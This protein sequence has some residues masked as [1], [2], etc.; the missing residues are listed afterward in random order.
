MC[1]E[2]DRSLST[3]DAAVVVS[4]HGTTEPLALTDRDLE[5]LHRVVNAPKNRLTPEYTADER[6]RLSA[7]SSVG[8]VALPDGPTV[9]IRPK[10]GTSNL[11]YLL[12]YGTGVDATTYDAS[13]PVAAGSNFVEALGALYETELRA[14]LRQG[15][16]KEYR[17]VSRNR[18]HLRGRLEVH[19]Q[20]GETQGRPPTSFRCTYDELTYDTPLN[21][22][23]HQATR[24]LAATVSD[25]DLSD[26]LAAHARR[27]QHSVTP[28]PVPA[29]TVSDIE[30]SR[31]TA[32]YRDIVRLVE[33]VLGNSFLEDYTT[34][35]NVSVSL[36]VN[37]N[38]VFERVVERAFRA[39]VCPERGLEVLVRETT[40]QLLPD[41]RYEVGLEPDVAV[42]MTDGTVLCV[43]DAKWK[44][45]P[46]EN[47]DVYQ[48]AA[49]QQAHDCPGVLVYPAQ[50][51]AL[52]FSAELPG[53]RRT[54]AIELP[55]GSD[56]EDYGS[57]V[58]TVEGR[59]RSYLESVRGERTPR[60]RDG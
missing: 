14:L 36:L 12:Q 29:R 26:R 55:T 45:G 23:I 3:D 11:L 51:R 24:I 44:T 50:E 22:A 6:V 32:H 34:G 49:Y 15:L 27:I 43:A 21:R 1:P 53:G 4:E 18:S 56:A 25:G 54:G 20:V 60:S 48:L 28:E 33:M 35:Q 37:M 39:A 38:T 16:R 41:N 52:E 40:G 5:F 13:V 2:T 57:F 59:A 19:E 42:Q 31:L 17:T 46:P 9:E 7:S 10:V 47:A 8:L 58:D 30:L